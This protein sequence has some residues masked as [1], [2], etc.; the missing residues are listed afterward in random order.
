M[1]D[2]APDLGERAAAL[3]R[4]F[5]QGFAEPVRPDA[6]ASEDFLGIV[7]GSE[8]YALRLTEIAGLFAGKKITRLPGRRAGLLGIAGFRGAILPVYGLQNLLGAGSE[9]PPRW[10]AVAAGAP[11]ALAFEGLEGQ[12][13]VMPDAVVPRQAQ[14][15]ASSFTRDVVRL[16]GRALPVLHLP[17]ILETIHSHN[18]EAAPKGER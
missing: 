2:T 14:G 4:A 7:V 11:V 10:L 3:R 17:S 16:G 9:A 8:A 15:G 6:A 18:R 12:L 5:D 13:R 1:S